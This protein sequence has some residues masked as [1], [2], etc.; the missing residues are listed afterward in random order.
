MK[1]LL[2]LAC[3]CASMLLVSVSSAAG[4]GVLCHNPSLPWL[5]SR[6]HARLWLAQCPCYRPLSQDILL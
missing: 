5:R 6:R 3:C 1:R 4:Q 2:V